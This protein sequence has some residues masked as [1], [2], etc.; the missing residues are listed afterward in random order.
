M[1]LCIENKKQRERELRLR[2]VIDTTSS[3]HSSSIHTNREYVSG[4][5]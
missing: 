5:V 4:D 2:L 3:I 1:C